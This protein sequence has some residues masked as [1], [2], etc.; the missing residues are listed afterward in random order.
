V[1]SSKDILA[2]ETDLNPSMLP[3]TIGF[4]STSILG[5]APV[6]ISPSVSIFIL[7]GFL[8]SAISLFNKK[9]AFLS[10]I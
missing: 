4:T 3:L 9:L 5:I 8:P 1:G 7:T 10:F 6:G 2:K